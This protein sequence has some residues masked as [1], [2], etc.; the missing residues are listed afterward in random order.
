MHELNRQALQPTK[1]TG[2][3]DQTPDGVTFIQKEIHYM[4]ADEA[5]RAGYECFHGEKGAMCRVDDGLTF[6]DSSTIL[7]CLHLFN[8]A[9]PALK[10]QY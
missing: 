10:G 4:T 3:A 8:P 7:K 2:R 9:I 1:V 5:G 6:R